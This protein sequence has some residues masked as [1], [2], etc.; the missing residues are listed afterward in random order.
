MTSIINFI[1]S[2]WATH[3]GIILFAVGICVVLAV[4][5]YAEN[6]RHKK[7]SR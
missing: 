4:C 2:V 1:S 3:P 6:I 5:E 7:K